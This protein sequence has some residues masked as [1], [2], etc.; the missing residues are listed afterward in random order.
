M[1]K[2]FYVDALF[3]ASLSTDSLHLVLSKDHVIELIGQ[4]AAG[5]RQESEKYVVLISGE[6]GDYDETVDLSEYPLV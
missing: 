4:L 6:M 5:L 2:V 3:E 1:D